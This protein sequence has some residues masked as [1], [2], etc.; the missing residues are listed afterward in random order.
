MNKYLLGRGFVIY[1][2]SVPVVLFGT[3]STTEVFVEGSSA[4][5]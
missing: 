3:V 5:R 2:F 4:L 1:V